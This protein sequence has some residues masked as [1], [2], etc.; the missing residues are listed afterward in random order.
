MK[1]QWTRVAVVVVIAGM[2]H[3]CAEPFFMALSLVAGQSASYTLDSITYKTFNSSV[4][5]LE[6]ATLR[7]LD[8][9]DMIV[10]MNEARF[11]EV[12]TDEAG[13]KK[14]GKDEPG[15]TKDGKPEAGTTKGG[16]TGAGTT[17]YGKP[18]AGTTKGGKTGAAT[19][20]GGKLE[21]GTKKGGIGEAGRSNA[22]KPDARDLGRAIAATAGDRIIEIELDRI[23]E[24]AS[25]MRVVVKQGWF[26]KDRATATEIILQTGQV[27]EDSPA[28]ARLGKPRPA[29]RV[30]GRAASEAGNSRNGSR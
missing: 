8:R 18:G 19:T 28:L 2:L 25:R 26:Y 5:G 9:M 20:K 13:T 17:N 22:A 12:G 29:A 6:A 30:N 14:D 7:A 11:E 21:A 10:T 1:P 3:G 27:F 23:T 15:T 16:K 4:E 24:R